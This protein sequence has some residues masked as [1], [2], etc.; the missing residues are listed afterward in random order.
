MNEKMKHLRRSVTFFKMSQKCITGQLLTPVQPQ[1][2][3][4]LC[5]RILHCIQICS[6]AS[7]PDIAASH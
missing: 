4:E 7:P 6:S 5:Q 1:L 2:K 3:E